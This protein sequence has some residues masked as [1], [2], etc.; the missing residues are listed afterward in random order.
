MT[1][2]F[3]ITETATPIDFDPTNIYA[4]RWVQGRIGDYDYQAKIHAREYK[5]GIR[6]GNISKLY[7]CD[8]A[9]NK[10]SAAYSMEWNI[11]P[12][13][14]L[15]T[16]MVDA[17]VEHYADHPAELQEPSPPIQKEK[18]T[19]FCDKNWAR[20]AMTIL[21]DKR[22][23]FETV[24]TYIGYDVYRIGV[25]YKDKFGEERTIWPIDE[26]FL[27]TIRESI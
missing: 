16:E 15:V 14:E 22:V 27:N 23:V 9:A 12:E 11:P 19:C 1:T 10:K 24:Y 3:T 2:T 6:D 26:R 4:G 17:L 8:A 18:K 7:I 21:L 13:N 20:K 25:K 5:I